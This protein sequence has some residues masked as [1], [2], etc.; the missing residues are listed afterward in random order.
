MCSHTVGDL[1][2][3]RIDVVFSA[4]AIRSEQVAEQLNAYKIPIVTLNSRIA[5]GVHRYCVVR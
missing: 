4:L 5:G 2:R 1:A 3:Y